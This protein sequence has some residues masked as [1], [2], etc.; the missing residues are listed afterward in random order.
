MRQRGIRIQLDRQ[1]QF[2]Y[3]LR[4]P[5]DQKQSLSEVTV[6]VRTGRILQNSGAELYDRGLVVVLEHEGASQAAVPTLPTGIHAKKFAE[7]S[8]GGV[9]IALIAI[10]VPQIV[11]NHGLIR[12]QTLGFEIFSD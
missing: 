6:F 3:R 7:L 4:L 1:T 8:D 2:A 12:R 9:V 10:R 11:A 5:V